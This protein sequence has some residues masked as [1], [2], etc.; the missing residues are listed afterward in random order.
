MIPIDEMLDRC[1]VD[2]DTP[3]LIVT[4]MEY[5]AEEFFVNTILYPE[6][7]FTCHPSIPKGKAL[8]SA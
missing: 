2:P 3:A 1:S 4:S 6:K 5:H 8:V 7:T